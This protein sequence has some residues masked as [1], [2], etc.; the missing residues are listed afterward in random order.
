[1]GLKFMQNEETTEKSDKDEMRAVI[2]RAK[3][4]YVFAVVKRQLGFR[5]TCYRGLAK[6]S[7]KFNVMFALA[8]LILVDR[9]SLPA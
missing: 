9:I 2:G 6:Q 3:V 1:M 8:N 4:E 5:Q 7:A